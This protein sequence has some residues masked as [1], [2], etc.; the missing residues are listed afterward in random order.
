MTNI[1]SQ[2]FLLESSETLAWLTLRAGLQIASILLVAKLLGASEYGYFV[3]IFATVSLFSP[4]AGLGLHAVIV[5]DGSASPDNIRALTQQ[6]IAIWWKSAFTF[7]ILA[8]FAAW[9]T[10]PNEHTS[11]YAISLFSAG[12]IMSSTGIELIARAKQAERK[13]RVF[14]ALHTGLIA[15][16]II[17][18]GVY[19]LIPTP[20]REQW[21]ILFGVSSLLYLALSLHKNIICTDKPQGSCQEIL[22]AGTPFWIGALSLRLQAEFNKPVLAQFSLSD[23]GTYNIAQ[24]AADVASLPITALQ[25]SLLP[26]LL[27]SRSNKV[28]F[29]N[30]WLYLT[31]SS[32]LI[33]LI[34]VATSQ[35]IPTILGREFAGA[36]ELISMLA[37]LPIIQVQRSLAN[38]RVVADGGSHHL[39]RIY[40]L[41]GL[42]AV[43][44]NLFAIANWGI[45][46]A[47][48][49]TYANE[50]SLILALL[51]CI[52]NTKGE[53]NDRPIQRDF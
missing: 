49:A 36:A 50:I 5:R 9:F 8:T 1:P 10:L 45:Q 33:S 12:E 31:A 26:R 39:T 28:L 7:S 47:I 30:A 52:K 2:K 25:E 22:K 35:V 46:G 11:F 44:A 4:I 43:T 19:S 13:L 23:T 32:A 20:C 3:A 24:R 29:R 17:S 14:G 53:T 38:T 37:G 27:S 34:M 40:L 18:I 42:F 16:K 6:S 41:N 15:T 48:L 21:M 51:A